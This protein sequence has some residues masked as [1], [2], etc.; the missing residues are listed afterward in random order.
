MIVVF[1]LMAGGAI[2]FWLC[3][4]ALVFLYA[5]LKGVALGTK[6]AYNYWAVRAKYR[7]K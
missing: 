6:D 5:A 4:W 3:I 7:L 2:I 1:L